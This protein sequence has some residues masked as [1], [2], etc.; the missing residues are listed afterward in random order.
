MTCLVFVY[1]LHPIISFYKEHSALFGRCNVVRLCVHDILLVPFMSE[2]YSIM[3]Q[4]IITNQNHMQGNYEQQRETN[5]V[6]ANCAL[7][8]L[9]HRSKTGSNRHDGLSENDGIEGTERE[10]EL[11]E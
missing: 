10:E 1:T 2:C 5:E 8:Q 3:Q 9:K 6:C 11:V 4:N 7:L